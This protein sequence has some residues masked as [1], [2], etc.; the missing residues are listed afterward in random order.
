MRNFK[1]YKTCSAPAKV[2]TFYDDGLIFFPS[3]QRLHTGIPRYNWSTF[4]YKNGF[5]ARKDINIYVYNKTR[6]GMYLLLYVHRERF[7]SITRGWK[8]QWLVIAWLYLRYIVRQGMYVGHI[9]MCVCFLMSVYIISAGRIVLIITV[10]G[11]FL[12]GKWCLFG[13]I[14]GS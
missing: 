2:F 9:V 5:Y 11:L 10:M 4:E 14:E 3:P 13:S 6:L 7:V 8:L 12:T 1:T